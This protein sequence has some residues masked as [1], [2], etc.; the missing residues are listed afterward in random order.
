MLRLFAAL[1]IPESIALSLAPIMSGLP[2]AR[3]HPPEKLHLTLRFFGE[4]D[5]G[6]ADDLDGELTAIGGTAFD[7]SLQGVGAFES[8]GTPHHLWA[9]VSPSESLRDLNRRCERAARRAGL[10]PDSRSYRPHITLAY[11]DRTPAPQT[12]AWLAR[13][14]LL[15]T[16]PIRAEGFH[17]Y[18]S[19]LSRR[20]QVYQRERTYPLKSAA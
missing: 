11:L 17:L 1:A 10:A 12:A 3:W 20:G 8:R 16:E 13:H 2:G 15:R 18:S 6:L 14:N 19:R 4:I 9:G 7:L 5:E